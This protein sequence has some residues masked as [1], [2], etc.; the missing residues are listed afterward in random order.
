MGKN[1]GKSW[2]CKRITVSF[3]NSQPLVSAAPVLNSLQK[4]E[5]P[6]RV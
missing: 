2:F 1:E 4:P 5:K 6:K 3:V